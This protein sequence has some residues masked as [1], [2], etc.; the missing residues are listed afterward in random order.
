[1]PRGECIVIRGASGGERARRL[2]PEYQGD[3][4]THAV[5]L[6][7]SN[8]LPDNLLVVIAAAMVPVM[9]MYWL[10]E[11]QFSKSEL[12]GPIQHSGAWGR[13]MQAR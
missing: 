7:L 11:K 13:T 9:G 2:A 3:G 10:I 12:L 6:Q 1:M 5:L 8:L 4:N